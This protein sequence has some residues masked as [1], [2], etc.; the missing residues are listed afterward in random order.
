M[1]EAYTTCWWVPAD[2]RPSTDEAERR[3]LHLRERGP[4]PYA[5]TL[6]ESYPPPDA[7]D[8]GRPNFR[9]RRLAQPSL[10]SVAG[11]PQGIEDCDKPT[12]PRQLAKRGVWFRLGVAARDCAA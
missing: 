7:A 1:R 9:S 6:R 3:L 11:R 4:T 10:S 12:L 5:F 8:S 2:H